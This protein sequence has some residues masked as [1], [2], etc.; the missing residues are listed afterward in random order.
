MKIK[1]NE[2]SKLVKK[3]LK[4]RGIK[5]ANISS[6]KKALEVAK[7]HNI[8]INIE[9]LYYKSICNIGATGDV[10]VGDMV[11]FERDIF[12][13]S[14]RK[15]KYLGTETIVAKI[16]KDSYGDKKQQ[17]T[18][19]CLNLLT[20]E[21]FRIKG[22]NLY[23]NGVNRAKWDNEEDRKDALEEKHSRGDRARQI[24]DIG[25]NSYIEW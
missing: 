3:V 11:I 16:L 13:G 23:K 18:F 15:P 8:D 24:R 20:N 21:T 5:I 7:G 12:G 17:H 4:N 25:R 1:A 2:K 14:W 19:T 22:R 10:V 6:Y 9:M